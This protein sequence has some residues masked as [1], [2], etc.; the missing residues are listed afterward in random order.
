MCLVPAPCR[1]PGVPLLPM[2]RIGVGL[3]GLGAGGHPRERVSSL[4]SFPFLP[5]EC[6]PEVTELFRESCFTG[7]FGGDVNPVCDQLCSAKRAPGAEAW[8][9]LLCVQSPPASSPFLGYFHLG[10]V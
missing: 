5:Q 10:A 8:F 3:A 9:P 4:C 2:H 1:V 7:V 6:S